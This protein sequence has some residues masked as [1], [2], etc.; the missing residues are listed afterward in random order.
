MPPN[1]ATVNNPDDYSISGLSGRLYFQWCGPKGFG[2]V[3][4]ITL[5]DGSH[6]IDGEMLKRESL[7]LLMT[8]LTNNA[9]IDREEVLARYDRPTSPLPRYTIEVDDPFVGFDLVE[10]GD[11]PKRLNWFNDD[12]CDLEIEEEPM[13]LSSDVSVL[14]AKN[15]ELEQQVN[16]LRREVAALH[17]L[18]E[19]DKNGQ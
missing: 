6:Y 14:E 10:Y 19:I 5:D 11:D 12:D 2:E 8:A 13:C 3:E 17:T 4:I 7:V 15:I 16:A 9:A 1:L 18:K